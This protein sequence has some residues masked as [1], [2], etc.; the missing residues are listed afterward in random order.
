MTIEYPHQTNFRSDQQL[1]RLMTFLD[2]GL[3]VSVYGQFSYLSL[4]CCFVRHLHRFLLLFGVT[5]NSSKCF[6]IPSNL[7]VLYQNGNSKYFPN[8][9]NGDDYDKRS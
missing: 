4:I 3:W 6:E 9:N 5:L 2:F 7:S 1:Y 8:S